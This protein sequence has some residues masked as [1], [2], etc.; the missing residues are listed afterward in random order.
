[1]KIDMIKSNLT[2]GYELVHDGIFGSGWKYVT[3]ALKKEDSKI[4]ICID[5]ERRREY[6]KH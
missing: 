3:S 6:S 5:I 1:M 2:I 4:N